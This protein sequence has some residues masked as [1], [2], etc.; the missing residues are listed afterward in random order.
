MAYAPNTL[1]GTIVAGGY[2][3]G[4]N[5]NQL[6]EPFDV[7][8]D[9]FTNSL[10]ISNVLTHNVVRWVI[11]ANHWILVAGGSDGSPGN[12]GAYLNSPRRFTL[13]PMGNLYVADTFNHRIQLFLSGQINGITIVG[14]TGVNGNNATLFDRPY[15]V[16]LDTQLNLY[17]TDTYNHRIQK[18]FRY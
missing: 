4:N 8:F 9:S 13:D 12:T 5:S 16:A 1:S 14:S 3:V 17:V 10:L 6:S 7:H 18:F 11:D 2:G 15:S